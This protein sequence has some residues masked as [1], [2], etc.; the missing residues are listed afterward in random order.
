PPDAPPETRASLRLASAPASEFP[1][2]DW[3]QPPRVPAVLR[4]APDPW[5]PTTPPLATVAGPI[6]PPAPWL[7]TAAANARPSLPCSK[8][9]NAASRRYR[10][11]R[12]LPPRAEP[13]PYWKNTGKR[14]AG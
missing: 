4:I 5:R 11:T 3:R 8:A 7:R 13:H 6:P 12:V 2:A 9:P 10:Q 1:A 14:W